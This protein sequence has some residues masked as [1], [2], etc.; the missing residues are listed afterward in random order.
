[1]VSLILPTYNRGHCLGQAV[2][3]VLGQTYSHWELIISDN[4]DGA[5]RFDDS[6]VRVIDTREV[7]SATYARNQALPHAR[8]DLVGFFD[9]DDALEPDYLESFVQ[10][11][12]SRP[13][14]QL[15]KCLMIRRGIVNET[16]GTP[17]VLLRRQ[18]ATP[19]WQP[20]WRQDRVYYAEIIARNGFSEED[21]TLV[22]LPRVL[23]HSGVDPRGG[24]REGNL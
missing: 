5:Y 14:V 22:V 15:V 8:G 17:T 3:S 9:D 20:M 12:E 1:M 11:F 2:A 24:L 7:T 19:T 23:C 4:G 13:K 18:H 16:Y 10:V 6:R 21:G